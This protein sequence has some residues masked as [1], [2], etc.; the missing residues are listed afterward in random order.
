MDHPSPTSSRAAAVAEKRRRIFDAASEVIMRK[1]YDGTTM[2]E[3]AL[4]AA[5]GKG[6]LYN[7]FASKDDLFLSL[8]LDGFERIREL[9]DAEVEPF[10]DPWE[11]FAI[12]WRALMLGIFPQLNQQWP[13]IYQLWGFLARDAEA[14]E[15][16]FAAWRD[17]YRDREHRIVTTIAEGQ[18]SGRFAK[19]VPPSSVALLLMATFDGLLHR[20]MFD[21]ERVDPETVLRDIL[22]LLQTALDPTSTRGKLKLRVEGRKSTR[23]QRPK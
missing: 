8:V 17:L 14:R 20:A 9:V 23:P 19:R 22:G 4:G 3:I 6:T 12:G 15:R 13:L 21:P 16:M 18:K 11:R 1:G 2:E 10:E 5:V 7:F